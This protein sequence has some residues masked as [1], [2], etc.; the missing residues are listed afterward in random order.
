MK[1]TLRNPIRWLLK[2]SEGLTLSDTITLF[3]IKLTYLSLR[4][5][6]RLILGKERRDNL[7]ITK[8]LDFGAYW[9]YAF[10][11]LH[12]NNTKL[13]KFKSRRYGF[14]FFCRNNKDDFKLMTIHEDELMKYFVPEEGDIVVDVG[15]HIGL[16]TIIASKRVGLSG[17]V[18]SIEPDPVNFEILG[19]N[20][21]I[22]HLEN[23]VALNYAL[24]LKKAIKTYIYIMPNLA[25]PNTIL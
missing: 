10:K 7:C 11:F 5:F 24:I 3:L 13:L 25:L 4:L 14:E 23:V 21:R 9:Y 16:Y 22:N 19:K 6:L 20:I 2:E 15:A 18:F 1:N 12:P 17:K 8:E